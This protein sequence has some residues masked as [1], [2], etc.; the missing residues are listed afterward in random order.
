MRRYSK[1][2]IVGIDSISILYLAQ[3]TNRVLAT[4]CGGANFKIHIIYNFLQI[5]GYLQ[6]I[7][8][9][10]KDTNT[11]KNVPM[12]LALTILYK[13]YLSFG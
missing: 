9:H 3:I 12:L 11:M 4:T 10:N 1:Y 2:S 8:L 5:T 7:Y 6:N 13:L